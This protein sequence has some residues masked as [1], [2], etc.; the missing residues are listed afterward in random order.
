MTEAQAHTDLETHDGNESASKMTCQSQ[1]L[2]NKPVTVL[3]LPP[4]L[5][6]ARNSRHGIFLLVKSSGVSTWRQT[7]GSRRQKMHQKTHS[8]WQDNDLHI[9]Q[10]QF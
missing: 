9:T 3:C 7:L 2:K 10:F 4:S 6:M 5:T 1:A 8:A